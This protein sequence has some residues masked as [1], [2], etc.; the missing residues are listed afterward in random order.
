MGFFGLYICLLCN[1]LH[2][3]L[4][5]FYCIISHESFVCRFWLFKFAALVAVTVGAFYI[6]DG[7]FT[8]SKNFIC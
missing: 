3:C 7:P 2:V 8:Y 6:P 1:V 5:T 4:R